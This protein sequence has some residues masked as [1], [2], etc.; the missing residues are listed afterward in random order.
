MT[1]LEL[2]RQGSI[3]DAMKKVAED[4]GR[5]A[6]EIR[7]HIAAGRLVLPFNVR[8]RCERVC[9]IG[10]GL[11]TKVNANIG[12][13]GDYPDVEDEMKKLTAAVDAGADAVM[14]L[15]TGGDIT[16]IRER[17]LAEC[18]VCVGSVPIYHAAVVASREKGGIHAMTANGMLDAVR[19]H[20]EQGV[21]FVTVH[22]GVTRDVIRSLNEERRVCGVV[23][24]GGAFLVDWITRN[25]AENPL[26]ERYD[27]ILDVCREYDVTISLGDGLRP[28]CL[29][30]AFDR[31]QIHELN[32]M[33]QLARRARDAGV[34]VMIEGPGHVP[35][36]Q[37]AAQ[38]KLQKALCDGAPF[39]VLG[40]IVTDVAPGYDHITSAIGGAIAAAAGADFLCYVTPT[41]HLGLPKPQ[42]VREGVM[43]ARIAAHAG[44][45]AK[46][47]PG[48]ADWDR[49]LSR[50]RR[51]R[52]WK[53][54]LALCMDPR[55][56]AALRRERNPGDQDV[57]SMCGQ[58]C[59]FKIVD[60]D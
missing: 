42:H 59:V 30:D 16:A 18:P 34:Q 3:S 29:A 31:P 39:Y 26:Y 35:L 41:E 8:R 51:E 47:V 15:S 52:D 22:C 23:S 55:R 33:A 14:D 40:P 17:I 12:A 24:R 5:P 46:G 58:Y 54:L 37:V 11:R 45:I 7:E 6:E 9:G 56:A 13:S 48:A 53:G 32:V 1:Q 50:L 43:A 2:A 57:C 44:D 25:E 28:G 21:D 20:C 10:Q 4:E 38:V 49:E 36:D 27:E 60:G 19:L